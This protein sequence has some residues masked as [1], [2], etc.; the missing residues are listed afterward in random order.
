MKYVDWRTKAYHEITIEFD[1]IVCLFAFFLPC[2]AVI[3]FMQT[4]KKYV[5]I[6]S[7]AMKKG[8]KYL[9]FLGM[10]MDLRKNFGI[11]NESVGKGIST[12][13]IITN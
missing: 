5:P 4:E 12:A 9:F 6:F 1:Y 3:L 7:F 13:G 2:S 8:E 10:E 11:F